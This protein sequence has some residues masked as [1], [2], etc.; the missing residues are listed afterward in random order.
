MFKGDGLLAAQKMFDGDLTGMEQIIKEKKIDLNKLQEETGYTLLMYASIIEDLKAMEK[1]MELGAD[2]NIII[3]HKGLKSPLNHA[4]A[5]NNYDML[6]L[7][8]KYKVNPNP[9]LGDSPLSDAMMIGGFEN[10]EKKMIDYLLQ[11][12]ASINN[13]SYNGNNI[14]ENA[15]RDDLD[16]AAYLL[17]KGGQPIISGT[18]LCPMADQIQF[19]EE[20]QIKFQ[21]T[22]TPYFK[23]LSALKKQ[24]IEKYNVQFPYKQDTIAE[25]K[26]R[27]K[28]YE[29]LN[30]KDKISV[31][32]NKNYGENRYQQ[33]LAIVK[34]R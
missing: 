8:F 33:D 27:I 26:L 6:Q 19:E 22:N 34:G 24:L 18:K 14:M 30:S 21:K 11:N 16:L 3:P 10:T 4:V 1:L 17:G 2:P 31:N 5:L 15:A 13:I 9:A 12:G 28:L 25:A 7:L 23:K 29:N 32:F 20:D